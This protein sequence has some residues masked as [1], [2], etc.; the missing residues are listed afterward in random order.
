MKP[1][2]F[3][4]CFLLT[5]VMVVKAQ[6][7]PNDIPASVDSIPTM[8]KRNAIGIN[9]GFP[10]IGLD[11]GRKLSGQLML[12]GQ[13]NFMKLNINDY[14]FQIENQGIL[15]DAEVN[16][17]NIDALLD[18]HPFKNSSF[19]MTIGVGY[20]IDQVISSTVAFDEDLLINDITYTPDQIGVIG[21]T[22]TWGSIAPY[23]G[24]GFGRAVPK[25][26]FGFGFELGTYYGGKP[27][28]TIIATGMLE[29]N[30]ENEAQL[31]EN[32]SEYRW[33]PVLKIRMAYKF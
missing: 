23:G 32:L 13:V 1:I 12:R 26:K 2:L 31:R 3:T 28:P 7:Q 6:E 20:F 4:F 5:I 30:V 27:K 24:I 17:L 19:R 10:G 11:Y 9:V 29:D 16:F 15:I 18:Y 14:S 33:L 21:L 22:N 8:E 25:G